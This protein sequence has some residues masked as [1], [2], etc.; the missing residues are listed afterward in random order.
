M[1]R[2]LWRFSAQKVLSSIDN[3]IG[4]G[5]R[6][7]PLFFIVILLAIESFPIAPMAL[8]RSKRAAFRMH[9]YFAWCTA[10][11]AIAKPHQAQW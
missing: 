8:V 3:K 10:L 1:S 9:T 4:E 7:R 5:A 6:K 11:T 2:R